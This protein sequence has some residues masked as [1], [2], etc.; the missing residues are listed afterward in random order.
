MNTKRKYLNQYAESLKDIELS[1]AAIDILER[2]T[3]SQGVIRVLKKRQQKHLVN[4]DLAA[5]KLGAPY[6]GITGRCVK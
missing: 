6:G 2:V 1:Q 4:L 3:G 5:E